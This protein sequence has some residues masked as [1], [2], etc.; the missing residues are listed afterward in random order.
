MKSAY[1]VLGVPANASTDEIEQAYATARAF[2][3]PERIA[4]AGDAAE[5]LNEVRTAWQVL[6]DPE[7][8]AA[9][10]RKLSQPVAGRPGAA[11]V[12]TRVEVVEEPGPSM[13]KMT[14]IVLL[15]LFAAGGALS[16][17]NAERRAEAAA[18]EKA[19]AELRLKQEQERAAEAR[20]IEDQQRQAQAQA[21]AAER[22]FAQESRA[23]AAQQAYMSAN[24][25]AA[26]ANARRAAAYESQRQDAA[27]SAED[28]RNYY[29]AQR[30]A[31]DDRQRVRNL[32]M[33]NYR[34]P[35]C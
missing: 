35:D 34:R 12:R 17:R 11:P 20:R 19:A 13:L 15:V 4:A 30:R 29:E 5:R 31:A 21:E 3:T 23:I 16:W 27:A 6:R 7:Q 26:A 2:Y 14:V 28:R 9:H 1:V 22:R 33:L 32:C 24:V 10:D 25:E 18:A 8:R